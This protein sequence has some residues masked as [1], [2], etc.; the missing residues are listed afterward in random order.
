MVDDAETAFKKRQFREV[1][2][3]TGDKRL[4]DNRD[5]LMIRG[6][7]FSH[8]NQYDEAIRT[9]KK[10]ATADEFLPNFLIGVYYVRVGN[11]KG[12]QKYLR[13]AQKLEPEHPTI[14]GELRLAQRLISKSKKKA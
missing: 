8:L 11:G 10:V 9:L 2:R 5:A 12:A 14:P 13:I 7:A 1:L 6:D 3:I 4:A